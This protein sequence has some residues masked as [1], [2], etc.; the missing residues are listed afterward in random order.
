MKFIQY[1]KRL[2]SVFIVYSFI[3]FIIILYSNLTVSTAFA[4]S[5][6][7]GKFNDSTA[8][9]YTLPTQLD[10]SNCQTSNNQT[11]TCG[12]LLFGQNLSNT[13]VFWNVFASNSNIS[14][15]PSKGYLELLNPV[16][17]VT[18]SNIPCINTSF[19]FSGQGG[20]IPAVLPWSCTPK[21]TPTP[22]RQPTPTPTH[23]PTP[24]STP[25]LSPTPKITSPTPTPVATTI[26]R[27][28]PSPISVISSISQ[29]DPPVKSNDNS[30]GN[31]FLV[32]ATIFLGVESCVAVI[33]IGILIRRKFFKRQ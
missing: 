12:V 26:P 18:I 6:Q 8:Y 5:D 2:Y 20:V 17:K 9:L 23:Q 3:A 30:S 4:L 15:S 16:N 32:S 29:N 28:T 7:L 11:W 33:L 13:S 25:Q 19:L 31:I 1:L 14:F 27:P 21:P 10:T 22:T 24:V